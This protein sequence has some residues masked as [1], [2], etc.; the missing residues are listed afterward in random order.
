[1]FDFS[2]VLYTG[3]SGACECI[4]AAPTEATRSTC[5]AVRKGFEETMDYDDEDDPYAEA[6]ADGGSN[7]FGFSSA[8]QGASSLA[9]LFGGSSSGAGGGDLSYKPP[10]KPKATPKPT[11]AQSTGAAS[12][13][14]QQ[15]KASILLSLRAREVYLL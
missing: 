7:P 13:H 4:C 14:Q 9:S 2:P 11:P 3:S 5:S 12:A 15:P 6:G 1:M 8:A 10:S